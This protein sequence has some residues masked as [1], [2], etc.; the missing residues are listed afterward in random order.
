MSYFLM[1]YNRK[2]ETPSLSRFEDSSEALA[3][4]SIREAGRRPEVEV[5]LL[6]ADSVEQ[7]KRTHGRY[8]M[9][10]PEMAERAMNEFRARMNELEARS[11]SV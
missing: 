9:T 4:L 5:V 2:T 1:E 8:F 11:L 10:I 6:I 7:L 3:A